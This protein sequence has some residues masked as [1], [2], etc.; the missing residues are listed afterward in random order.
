[1]VGVGG[2]GWWLERGIWIGWGVEKEKKK[3]KKRRGRKKEEAGR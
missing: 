1:M 3:K 2:W